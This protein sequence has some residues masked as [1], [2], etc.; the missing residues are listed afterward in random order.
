MAQL[1]SSEARQGL[2]EVVM[3][4]LQRWGLSPQR[5]AELLAVTDIGPFRDGEPLPDDP[6]V[7]ERAGHL[8]AIDRSLQ[9]LYGEDPVTQDHWV[10]FR[11]PELGDLSPLTL[12]LRDS[13]GFEKVRALLDSRRNRA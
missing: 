9:R 8:L 12:M 11:N 5:Q 4:L 3:A 6:G 13:K 1:H 2:A 10:T 7:L